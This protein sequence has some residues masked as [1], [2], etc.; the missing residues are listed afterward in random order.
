MTHLAAIGLLMT[1]IGL[2]CSLL[3][4]CISCRLY[5]E[6]RRPPAGQETEHTIGKP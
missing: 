3:S 2:S 4:L 1:G 6:L 5:R